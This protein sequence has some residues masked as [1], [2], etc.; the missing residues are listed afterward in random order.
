MNE[1]QNI[2]EPQSPAFLVGAVSSSLLL[3]AIYLL[4]K[5]QTDNCKEWIENVGDCKKLECDFCR[6]EKCISGLDKLQDKTPIQD[7]IEE[8]KFD[9]NIFTPPFRVGK[10]QKR[11]ILDDKGLEVIIMPPNSEIQAQMYCDYLNIGYL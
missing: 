7:L 4:R 11:A 2:N 9:S 1:E 10:F 6:I 3:E 8:L 5:S